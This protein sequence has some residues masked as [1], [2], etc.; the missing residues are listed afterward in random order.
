MN[1]CRPY[2]ISEITAEKRR[3]P[4]VDGAEWGLAIFDPS[5]KRV[6]L[7][8]LLFE[9]KA[10]AQAAADGANARRARFKLWHDNL[11]KQM[12]ISE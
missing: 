1:A 6:A 3:R 11:R 2:H 5:G 10:A 7:C 8:A 12:E 9:D 4:A